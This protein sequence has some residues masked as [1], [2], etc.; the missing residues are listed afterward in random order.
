MATAVGKPLVIDKATN[1]QTRPSCARVK[2][3][4]DLLKELPK[5]IQINCID[6]ETGTVLSKWQKIQYDYLS[7]YCT[8]CCLQG[9]ELQG[10]WVLHPEHRPKKEEKQEGQKTNDRGRTKE[11]EKKQAT[12]SETN[13]VYKNGKLVHEN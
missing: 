13:G 10:C 9:N 7:K 8:H 6:K 1:N 3:E 2:V 4:V 5:R 11:D 12:T